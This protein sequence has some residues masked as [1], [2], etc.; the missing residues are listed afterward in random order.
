RKTSYDPIKSF[1][2]ISLMANAP[3]FLVV[4]PSVAAR[5]T[6]ELIELS[7][8]KPGALNYA[9]GST[10]AATHLAAELFK[11]MAAVKIV[12][13]PYKGSGPAVI[14]L[15]GGQVQMMIDTGASLLPH[16]KSGK[17]RALAVTSTKPS[18]L[19]P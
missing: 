19:L 3:L 1:A 6:R 8:A 5:S 9:S 12:Q 10:G 15:I 11:A 7:K 17:L 2:P 4:Y 13:I 14:G 18:A 16:V